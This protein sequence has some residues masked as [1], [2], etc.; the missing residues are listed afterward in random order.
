MWNEENFA[1]QTYAGARLI[2]VLHTWEQNNSP[3]AL[4]SSGPCLQIDALGKLASARTKQ[5]VLHL[6]AIRDHQFYQWYLHD[7]FVPE[8]TITLEKG[9]VEYSLE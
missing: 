2:L 7:P 1:N 3:S 4:T 9:S 6:L 5:T 8:Q